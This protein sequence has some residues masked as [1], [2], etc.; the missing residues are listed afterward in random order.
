MKYK[1]RIEYFMVRMALRN[2]IRGQ[3]NKMKI[4]KGSKISVNYRLCADGPDGELIEETRKDEPM[5]FTMGDDPMLPKF[6]AALMGLEAGQSFKIS[7]P[8]VDAY[9]E[10]QENL[11]V[12]FPKSDF[13]EDGELDEEMFQEGEI[14]PMETPEGE[15]VEGVI[16]EVRLNSI[17]LDFNHPLAGEDLYFE[18]MVVAV[19]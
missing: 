5:E 19:S 11:F 6:E 14:V 18:G 16:C 15:I 7:I 1:M 9:G 4:T 12:E 3:Y 13:M 17:I 2:E 8:A 10:E